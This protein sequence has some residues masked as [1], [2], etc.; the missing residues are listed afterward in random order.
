MIRCC[1]GFC[2]KET[3]ELELYKIKAFIPTNGFDNKLI[4]MDCLLMLKL[5]YEQKKKNNKHS[6]EDGEVQ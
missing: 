5:Y 1:C 3:V 6:N 4:C 2:G